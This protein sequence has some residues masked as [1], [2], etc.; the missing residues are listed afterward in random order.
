MISLNSYAF[1]DVCKPNGISTPFK[2]F[3]H[4]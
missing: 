1:E 4:I 2:P 3:I